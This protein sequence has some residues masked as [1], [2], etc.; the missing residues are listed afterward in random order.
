MNNFDFMRN[1]KPSEITERYWVYETIHFSF[2]STH[3]T[4]KWLIAVPLEALDETW[5][6]VSEAL[7]AGRLGPAAKAATA[8]FNKTQVDYK[9]KMIVV[10]VDDYKLE[11]KT[12]KVL[13]A[14]RKLGIKQR[15]RFKRDIETLIG[16]Y[17]KDS[18]WIYSKANTTSVIRYA[19]NKERK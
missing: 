17:G 3:H 4:G 15:M 1:I 2:H 16:I 13:K 10:Y 18:F 7:R 8:M 6:K 11:E 19:W 9:K 12:K 5:E 14:L